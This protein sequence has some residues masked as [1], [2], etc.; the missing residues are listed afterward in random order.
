MD[1]LNIDQKKVIEALLS[2]IGLGVVVTDVT[3][4]VLMF[5][6]EATE[7]LG[8]GHE[9]TPP[10]AWPRQFGIYLPDGVTLCPVEQSPILR[11]ISGEKV[12]NLEVLIVPPDGE[13]AGRWCNIN[14]RPLKNGSLEGAVLVIQDISER[15][16]LTDEIFRSNEA[17]QQFASVA[18]HD[19]QEPLRTVSGFVDILSEEAEGLLNSSCIHYMTRIK[20]AVKHMRTLINDLLEFSR[21]QGRPNVPGLVNLNDV[22]DKCLESL[23]AR[24]EETGASV[25]YGNLPTIVA[26]SPQILQL[27]QNLLTNALKFSSPDRVPRVRISAKKQGQTWLFAVEDNGIGIDM[28]FAERIFILF[29]RLHANSEYSGTGIGLAVCKRIVESHGGRIWLESKIGEGST[30]YFTILPQTT[31]EEI[32]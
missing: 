26:D 9:P 5:N 21:V 3:G 2:G 10:E 4:S 7:I 30:F 28:Q 31:R 15:K 18:A 19:L 17:L 27:F 22:V 32:A 16:Q 29:Q 1:K 13:T 20:A 24:V 23:N 25:T 12:D 8:V 6:Q 14:L 11:A